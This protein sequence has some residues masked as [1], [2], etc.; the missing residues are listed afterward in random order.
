MEVFDCQIL[1]EMIGREVIRT[2]K[3]VDLC[4]DCIPIY[5][6]KTYEEILAND[7]S[8]KV[9]KKKTS[10]FDQISNLSYADLDPTMVDSIDGDY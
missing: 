6:K 5:Y 3:E 9:D 7:Q 1:N 8:V 4:K 2:D 10:E